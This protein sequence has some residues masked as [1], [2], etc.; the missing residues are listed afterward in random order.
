MPLNSVLDKGQYLPSPPSPNPGDEVPLQVDS[1]GNLKTT[2]TL[3]PGSAVVGQVKILGNAGVPIDGAS[4]QSAPPNA[5]Q[6]AGVDTGGK[7]RAASTDVLGRETISENAGIADLLLLLI[8]ETR[9]MKHALV[10][11]VTENGTAQPQDFDAENF[12]DADRAS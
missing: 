2:T 10:Q 4:G 12:M 6:I 9:A 3:Q 7:L 11:L 8:M 5:V 1:S